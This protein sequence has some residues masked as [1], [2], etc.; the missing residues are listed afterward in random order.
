MDPH[1]ER[2]QTSWRQ[3]FRASVKAA[4]TW[5]SGPTTGPHPRVL[6]YHSVDLGGSLISITPERFREQMRWLRLTGWKSLSLHEAFGPTPPPSGKNVVLT[7][8]DGYA[9]LFT[10][11][12]P[13]LQ[14]FGL[15]A[16]VFLVTD[17]IGGQA[18]WLARDREV[19]EDTVG[20]LPLPTESRRTH[21]GRLVKLASQRLLSWPQIHEMAEAGIEFHSHTASHPFLPDLGPA[22]AEEEVRRGMNALRAALGR[23]RYYFAY[24]YGASTPA[25]RACLEAV[26]CPGAFADRSGT[27]TGS[28]HDSL[29]LPRV[30][31]PGWQGLAD[32]RYRLSRA[33]DLLPAGLRGRPRAFR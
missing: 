15:T 18:D 22:Q 12:F 33:F 23:D 26:D 31:V 20:S 14:E 3:A 11:A 9:N 28:S 10:G 25:A 17:F 27:P 29:D 19:I 5:A 1:R 7:F 6:V 2:Q 8:D 16:A 4:L 30:P 32:F 21:L 13:I 24:P